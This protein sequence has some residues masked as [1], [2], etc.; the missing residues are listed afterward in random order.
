MKAKMY[1]LCRQRSLRCLVGMEIKTVLYGKS[2]FNE[3]YYK[4]GWGI[5]RNIYILGVFSEKPY[6][7]P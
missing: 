7:K 2:C 6:S 3:L 5:I 1:R 4:R